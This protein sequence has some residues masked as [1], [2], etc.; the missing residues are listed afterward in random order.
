MQLG[1]VMLHRKILN[2]EWYTDANTFKLFVH[3]LLCAN[4]TACRYRGNE[5][6]RGEY[7]TSLSS[8]ATMSG[9]TLRQVR[10]SLA[11]LQRTGEID[12]KTTQFYTKITVLK[13]DD[14]QSFEQ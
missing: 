9:L 6:G 14:Y 5:V 13:Y 1:F 2:W 10:T 7:I 3:L 8:L 12:V 4:H 11:R